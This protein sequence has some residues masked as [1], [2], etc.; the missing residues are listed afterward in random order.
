MGLLRRT[1][2]WT[3][4]R[5][6]KRPTRSLVRGMEA[7]ER[8]DRVSLDA[9]IDRR[10]AELAGRVAREVPHYAESF[11]AAGVA[12]DG[13]RRVGDLA[14]LPFLDKAAI[15]AAATGIV[16]PEGGPFRLTETGGSTGDPLKIRE[17]P[18][19][20]A[21]AVAAR[22]RSRAWWGIEVGDAELVLFGG[23]ASARGALGR[24]KDEV[25]G[26]VT[27]SAF[28]M[29]PA[30]LD[31]VAARLA[32]LRPR[33]L[34]GY[35]SALCAFARHL[36]ESRGR[37]D[38]G[39]GHGV[40]V[41]FTTSE[42]LFPADRALLEETF[43]ARVA[44]GYGSKEAGFIAHECREGRMHV[45]ADTH[46][47]EIVAGDRVVSAGEEGEIVATHLVDWH[48][49]FLRYRTG[50]AGTIDPTPCPCGLVLPV[51]RVTG[52]RITDLLV[53]K[54]GGLVHGL[55]A[56]YPVRETPGV[57]RFQIHQKA[58]DDVE[59]LLV[60]GA[61]YPSDGDA[62]IASRLSETLAG[63]R[64]SVRHVDAIE[65]AASGKY[66]VVRSD[67]APKRL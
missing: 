18:L 8:L 48:W 24:L 2:F 25:L 31:D 3:A 46:V 19:R 64:V 14:R 50:D 34:F 60:V 35:T 43:G 29:T 17:S 32:R 33:H 53:R 37:P 42:M 59:V 55:G 47:V 66:R 49:P 12:A 21:T 58:L 51:L 63:A 54:D 22:I 52:G 9:L 57:V 4:E 44:D 36:R 27:Y 39:A 45:R 23:A 6:R 62:R 11:R 10:L 13:V 28:G 41:V 5:L 65:Q 67:V 16:H 7:A 20:Q 1:A 56:I 38:A 30:H 26:S 40:E 61:G 15:R